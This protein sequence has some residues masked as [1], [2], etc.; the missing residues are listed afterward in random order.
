MLFEIFREDTMELRP[1][2]VLWTEMFYEYDGFYIYRSWRKRWSKE[3][4]FNC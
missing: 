4:S 3:M 1:E 2:E